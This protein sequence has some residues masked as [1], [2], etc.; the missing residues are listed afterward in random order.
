MPSLPGFVVSATRDIPKLAH[1]TPH[2]RA[3]CAAILRQT[4]APHPS[5]N[6]SRQTS[7]L[8]VKALSGTFCK[9]HKP[10]LPPVA[11]HTCSLH[12]S[13]CAGEGRGYPAPSALGHGRPFGQVGANPIFPPFF[14]A[15]WGGEALSTEGTAYGD[16]VAVVGLAEALRSNPSVTPG[17]SV[18][19]GEGVRV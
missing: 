13:G 10:Y 19:G 5:P 6:R 14:P 7:R 2:P 11:K 8:C 17:R 4:I 12:R 3:T 9:S 15:R 16:D 1:P 18:R